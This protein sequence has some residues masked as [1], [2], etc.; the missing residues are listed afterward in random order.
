MIQLNLCS[1]WG[2]TRSENK[3]VARGPFLS[4]EK[5]LAT[6]HSQRHHNRMKLSLCMF[7]SFIA[8]LI[9]SS[10]VQTSIPDQPPSATVLLH[11]LE[12]DS[13]GKARVN[14]E[15]KAL[16]TGNA[17][18]TFEQTPTKSVSS[19]KQGKRHGISTSYFYNGNIRQ[20]TTFVN[21]LKQGP[22]KEYRISG[23]LMVEE[24][25]LQDNLHGKK[26]EFLPNGNKI[27]ELKT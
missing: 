8:I 10:C 1:T 24:A 3:S 2:P 23:E 11:N 5:P 16:F 25:Y 26:I 12:I 20:S 6:N 14:S 4:R 27:M 17:V 21:G 7:F 13:D 15:G 22:S 9:L 19:W 18:E